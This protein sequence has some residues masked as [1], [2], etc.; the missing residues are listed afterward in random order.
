MKR[1]LAVLLLCLAAAQ[2]RAQCTVVQ[3]TNA[4]FGSV[5]S[6]LVNTTV[7]STSTTNAGLRCSGSLLSLLRTD[8]F[9]K[10]TLTPVGGTTGLVGPTGDVIKY[11]IYAD[12]TTS[13]PIT[14]G[15]PFDFARHGI[16][17]ALGLLGS[18]VP[19]T[20]PL[21][22]KTLTGSNVAA[23]T[24][25]ETFTAFWDWDYCYGIGIGGLCLGRQTT[26][27][28]TSMTVTLTVTADCQI[29]TPTI[30]F[31][32][33]PVVSGF[34]TVNQ[35]ISLSCT[36]GSAYTVGLNDGLYVSAGRRR[37]KLTTGT[38]Y[39]AYDIFKSA[40]T[41]R[42]GS[43][44][45]ARRASSDAD[46]NPGNGTGTGSQVFNYNAKVY[47]DQATPPAGAYQ[48]SVILDVAF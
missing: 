1:W 44:T 12:N 20:V 47:T 36:K 45:T 4:A 24:Y 30:N 39:L 25:T 23:G 11:T 28:T 19:S 37:M 48:D 26:S 14:R 17:E 16:L 5:A 21:Y 32:T 8:D 15:Q 35:S 42:W 13:F 43:L 22:F 31:G 46:I 18:I 10:L 27:G 3:A 6:T 2:A 34:S 29:T 38:S 40:G 9:F 7:Q 41:T 33:A